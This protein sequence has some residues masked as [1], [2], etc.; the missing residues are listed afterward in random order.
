MGHS[1][2]ISVFSLALL[3][4]CSDSSNASPA[5]DGGID[6]LLDA[7][8]DDDGG[9]DPDELEPVLGLSAERADGENAWNVSWDAVTGAQAYEIEQ[10][11][12]LDF[13][14]ATKQTVTEPLLEVE[15]APSAKNV[16]YYRVR[17]SQGGSVG[18][19]SEPLRVISGYRETFGE[20][21][22]DWK[23]RRTTYIE[24][25]DAWREQASGKSW[26][27]MQVS[28]RWDWGIVS[29]LIPAPAP[30]YAIEYRAQVAEATWVSSHGI[31]FAG[32]WNGQLCPD[33]A[34]DVDSDAGWYQHNRCF[35]R[36]Y[37][38]NAIYNDSIDLLVERID[39]LEWCPTCGGSPMKRQG[40]FE[41]VDNV[42]PMGSADG[43]AQGWN[44][45]RIEV[46]DSGI[47][48]YVN[49]DHRLHYDDVRW[50]QQR[51][52]GFFATTDE[53]KNSTARFDYIEILPL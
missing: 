16:Y 9:P 25:V 3:A 21:R 51:Y 8:P 45:W 38:L 53:Y 7:A 52:F 15:E 28:D 50:I 33:P 5:G 41:L 48:V 30:P 37:T 24:E 26:L 47:D 42:V 46:R 32:D 6:A 13:N 20:G 44:T 1:I 19:W 40:D 18:P 27:V 29:P 34:A 49:N 23:I 22:G 35:N 43:Q 10:S 31:V 36:C 4:N 12:A 39:E 11:H 14:V 17:V 2:W